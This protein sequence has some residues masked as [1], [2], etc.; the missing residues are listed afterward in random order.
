M[1]TNYF[2]IDEFHTLRV[3]TGDKIPILD[4]G[5]EV[6]YIPDLTIPLDDE[7]ACLPEHYIKEVEYAKKRAIEVEN[8]TEVL[9]MFWDK[10]NIFLAEDSLR[11]LECNVEIK[12]Y[13]DNGIILAKGGG[14]KK[15]GQPE[16]KKPLFKALV[17][18]VDEPNK[19]EQGEISGSTILKA[20]LSR[21]NDINESGHPI[22]IMRPNKFGG[23]CTYLRY[24]AIVKEINDQLEKSKSSSQ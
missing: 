3:I 21:G 23:S 18:I 16:I 9:K 2:F 15:E 6:T 8:Q 1:E 14:Y 13:T 17:S 22:R 5:Q 10:F 4:F 7:E 19:E 24:D 12:A 20:L 11:P